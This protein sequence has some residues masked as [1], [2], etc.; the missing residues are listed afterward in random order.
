[1]PKIYQ[2][3]SGNFVRS[4]PLNVFGQ[5]IQNASFYAETQRTVSRIPA[6]SPT[7]SPQIIQNIL[8]A[9]AEQE[10]IAQ[11]MIV[12]I[13]RSNL[14]Q[15]LVVNKPSSQETELRAT[16]ALLETE[17][18][19]LR[20][21]LHGQTLGDLTDT[22]PFDWDTDSMPHDPEGPSPAS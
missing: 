10:A 20:K 21:Q 9:R 8:A 17:N 6:D 18:A 13:L 2:D 11:R 7:V 3:G 19:R 15:P 22:E 16:I 12:A 4:E 1:M 14:P 5:L